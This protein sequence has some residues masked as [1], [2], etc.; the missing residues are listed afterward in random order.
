MKIF[1]A[2]QIKN[3]DAYTIKHEPVLS[4]HLMERAATACFSWIEQHL[5]LPAA[6]N[7]DIKEKHIKIFC[8]KGNNGGDGLV[9]ARKLLENNYRATVYILDAGNKATEDFETN[10]QR[11]HSIT[12]QVIFLQQGAA[13]PLIDSS[14]I[15]IDAIF[16]TGLNKPLEG[17]TA[18]VV[19]HINQSN[20]FVIS[21][22]IPSGMFADK[23]CKELTTIKA[24]HTLS[25][26]IYKTC[27]LLPENEEAIGEVHIIKICLH[28]KFETEEETNFTLI[29][30]ELIQQIYRP[31]KKFAHK[32]TYGH[33]LI[34]AGSYGKMG[35]AQLAAKA[36]LRAGVGLLTVRIPA[37]GVEILQATIPEAMT[38]TGETVDYKKYNIIGAG[39]G[40]GTAPEAVNNIIS[41]INYQQL[42]YPEKEKAELCKLVLDADAL[43]ILSVHQEM[44]VQLSPN[45]IL[46]PHP[47]EFERLFGKSNSDF[48]RI[49]MALHNAAKYN[50]YII[51]KG[52]HSFI[53]TPNCRGYFNNTGN[54]GMATGGSG[55]VLTGILTGLAAQGYTALQT[56]ILGVYL[57]GLAGDIAAD[58]FSQEAMLA[59]DITH[60]LGK[61]FKTLR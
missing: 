41:I 39:P 27:F 10:L 47:K 7:I 57:H 32:G 49:E 51:L 16:G 44:L 2:Q 40:L 46:T 42:I 25:F 5:L 17:L 53:A 22:D 35:A 56:C 55:D 34:V 8:S 60:C 26:E 1:T 11:L 59:G 33:A 18:E 31:R 13:L 54:A 45:T 30:K 14:D 36:C 28:K 6:Q 4:I 43:N 58:L 20:A 12:T 38:V 3:W 24:S 21:I 19:N 23:S 48:E 61:A 15:I 29:D 52:H 50:C 37:T 9:I